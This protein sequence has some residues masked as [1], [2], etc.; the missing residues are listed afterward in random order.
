MCDSGVMV[1]VDT[2]M[3][4]RFKLYCC[5]CHFKVCSSYGKIFEDK[6]HYVIDYFSSVMFNARFD[7][8]K[9]DWFLLSVFSLILMLSI[10]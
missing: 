5:F 4:I 7:L 2:E 3:S 9:I 1:D 8:I 10:K 6:W